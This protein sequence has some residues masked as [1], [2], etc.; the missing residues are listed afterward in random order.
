MH[1]PYG[2][3]GDVM[4]SVFLLLGRFT[5]SDH[6]YPYIILFGCF[7]SHADVTLMQTVDKYLGKYNG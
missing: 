6:I 7:S 2:A 3:C 4:G 1:L 5:D